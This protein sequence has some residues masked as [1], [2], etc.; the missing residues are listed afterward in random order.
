[1][2]RYLVCAEPGSQ[3]LWQ[4]EECGIM[5]LLSRHL[6]AWLRVHGKKM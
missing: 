2:F 5:Y 1:M 6:T 4:E 3:R